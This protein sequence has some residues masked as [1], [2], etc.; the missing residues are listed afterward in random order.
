MFRGPVAAEE[1]AAPAFHRIGR[2]Y[3]KPP[4][5]ASEGCSLRLVSLA[6]IK[7]TSVKK[8]ISTEVNSC[9]DN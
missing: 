8:Y 3:F 4:I 5:D 2:L 7:K 9:K 6:R 1:G